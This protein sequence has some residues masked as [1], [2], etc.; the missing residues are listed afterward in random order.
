MLMRPVQSGLTLPETMIS[1]AVLVTTLAVTLPSAASWLRDLQVRTAAESLKSGIELAR[2]EAVRR[3]A[4]ISLRIPGDD[5]RL[6]AFGCDVPECPKVLQSAPAGEASR[7]SL[8]PQ[9]DPPSS[10]PPNRILFD[11]LGQV[12]ADAAA[13]S[14]DSITIT[15]AGSDRQLVL[16]VSRAGA[17]TVGGS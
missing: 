10:P 15:A 2:L 4:R 17:V 14:V 8:A 5:G 12:G 16:R 3:N 9:S 13:S 6:W 11:G 1:L 7:A